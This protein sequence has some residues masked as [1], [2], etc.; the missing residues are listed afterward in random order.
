ML[1]GLRVVPI[2][3]ISGLLTA[4]HDCGLIHVSGIGATGR[5]HLLEALRQA[6]RAGT[7]VSFDPNVRTRLW[8]DLTELRTAMRA[9]LDV[10]DIALPS[11]DDEA[12]LWGDADPQ[13]TLSR[14][15]HAGV[16]EIVVKNG[17]GEVA[18]SWSGRREILPTP[19]IDRVIDT[20]GAGDSFNAGYL[21]GR[22]VGL[23][24]TQACHIGQQLA[25]I[26]IGH[27]GALTPVD[28]LDH[29]RAVVQTPAN[30]SRAVH[31]HA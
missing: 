14:L 23:P 21:A 28:A 3:R 8:S 5:R 29:V 25:G 27:Y 30:I 11:F 18:C 16:Q 1:S 24:M 2:G 20:T 13:S 22:L 15:E 7:V 9:I 19:R 10:T 17:A 6:R 31:V 12:A 26:V 4:T